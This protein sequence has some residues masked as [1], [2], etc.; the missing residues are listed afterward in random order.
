M[1]WASLR[2]SD[3]LWTPPSR[4][5]VQPQ[6]AALTGF[7]IRTTSSREGMPWGCLLSG[8][9]GSA[10][11]SWGARFFSVLQQLCHNTRRLQPNRRIDF[12]P[13]VLSRSAACP[14]YSRPMKRPARTPFLLTASASGSTPPRPPCF[15]PARTGICAASRVTISSSGRTA[16]SH[17]T[18]GM[19]LPRPYFCNPR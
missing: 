8:L 2:W 13:A 5:V 11:C 9:T 1:V 6:Q 18:A 7:S 19:T 12:L 16:L 14:V 15:G 10:S 17:C 4:I 3:A